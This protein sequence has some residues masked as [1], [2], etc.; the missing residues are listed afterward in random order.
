MRGI[1]SMGQPDWMSLQFV[2]YAFQDRGIPWQLPRWFADLEFYGKWHVMF[3]EL[4]IG[5]ST[6]YGPKDRA[7]GILQRIGI[8]RLMRALRPKS[9]HTSNPVYCALLA[10]NGIPSEV[11]PLFGSVPIVTPTGARWLYEALGPRGILLDRRDSS[12]PLL[13]GVFGTIH[14]Q[15]QPEQFLA[16]ALKTSRG[17]PRQ[18]VLL[19]IGRIGSEGERA[20]RRIANRFREDLVCV[21]LGEQSLTRISEFLQMIDFGIATSPWALTGKS[22][23]VAAMLD[24]GVP[25]VVPRDDWML[26]KYSTPAPAPDPLLFRADDTFIGLLNEKLPR[27]NQKPRLRSSAGEFLNALRLVE[28]REGASPR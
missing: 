6:D 13:M 20:L 11:L 22:S 9:V 27:G 18:L 26:R 10:A 2:P 28:E 15:W 3:H 25:V 24:H 8:L 1:L 19:A 12:R 23:A 14:P 7:I 5:E 16:Q 17:I 21:N 4:W